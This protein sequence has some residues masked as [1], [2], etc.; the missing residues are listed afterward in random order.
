MPRTNIS[1]PLAYAKVSGGIVPPVWP[2]KSRNK[3]NF[4]LI[5]NM[6]FACAMFARNPAGYGSAGSHHHSNIAGRAGA[7]AVKKGN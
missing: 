6:I 5:L 2:E 4:L 1:P 3:T 7:A